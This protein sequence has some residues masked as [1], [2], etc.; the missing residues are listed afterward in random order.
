MKD[1]YKSSFRRSLLDMHIEEWDDRFLSLFDE[2]EIFRCVRE[3]HIKSPMFY[4]QSHVGYCYWPTKS[5]HMHK[6]FE[7]REGAVRD[8]FRLC[9]EAGM[10]PVA[11]YSLIYNN[12]AYGEHPEWR[13]LNAHGRGSRDGGN[14]YGLCCPNNMGYRDFVAEQIAEFSDYFE[15]YGIFLDMTFWPMVCYCPSCR[16]RWETETGGDMPDVVDWGDPR[17]NAFQDKRQEWIGDFA[18]FA[19]AEIKKHNGD[20]AVEHQYSTATGFWRYGV[21]AN[22]AQASDYAG[23]D[24]YGGAAEQSFACKLYYGLTQNQPFEYMTSRCDPDLREHTTNK[25]ADQLALAVYTTYAHHGA[26]LLIDAI[27]P[28]GAVD[29]GVYELIG[30]VFR[31]SEKLEPWLTKGD[32]VQDVG[33]YFSLDNKMDVG[34]SGLY[35]G[36]RASDDRSQPHLAAAMGAA[37][38]LRSGHIPFGVLNNR[39][40]TNLENVKVLVLPDV[41]R[42]SA[43]ER[44]AILDFIK[45]GGSAYLSGN[46]SIELAGELLGMKYEGHTEE[47]VTYI[48]PSE[49]GM[50]LMDG[51]RPD[52][53]MAVFAKQ[54]M[55]SGNTEGTVLGTVTLPYTTPPSETAWASQCCYA[56]VDTEAGE[57]RPDAAFASIHSNPPG[58]PTGYPAII[59]ANYGKGRVAWASAPVEAQERYRHRELFICMIM[60]M[61]D[62]PS[63]YSDDAPDNVEFI[64]FEE[65][66]AKYLSIVDLRDSFKAQTV[67]NFSVCVRADKAPERVE[68]LPSGDPLPFAFSDEY[69]RIAIDKLHIFLMLAIYE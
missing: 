64:M 1:W 28:D 18:R 66:G 11:Y 12:W 42:M 34:L 60:N 49:A 46:S 3:A 69:V 19:T 30:K 27:D 37:A 55:L 56:D 32:M 43:E 35:T 7:G 58:I 24:L 14:R 63:F 13:M 41:A 15:F 21:N 5:G 22:V 48:A 62:K 47:T 20:C 59:K 26:S 57:R 50:D 68:A 67:C 4:L 52:R 8:L 16:D 45:N 9:A 25:T 61:L 51:Y 2:N 10:D 40:L 6:A 23:G 17:W 39:K 54:A 29:P 33:V 31:E 38:A 36:S 65:T 53:P 44:G